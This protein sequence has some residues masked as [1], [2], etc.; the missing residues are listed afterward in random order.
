[1]KNK[2]KKIQITLISIGFILI[3][4]TY[5]YYPY[6]NKSKLSKI[7]KSAENVEKQISE[8]KKTIFKDVEY[9]GYYDLNK[10]FIIKSEEATMIN[11]EP[12]IV[13]MSKMHVVLYLSD[14]R[15]VNITS[16]QGRY[17]KITYDCYFEKNVIAKDG[18][19][20]ISAENLDLLAEENSVKAY[21]KV[22]INYSTGSLKAD[23]IDYDF[24]T[25]YFRVSMFGNEDVK[26][27]VV[28]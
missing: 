16:D 12:D 14:E 4:A 9:K 26:M 13:Y 2:Q 22:N 24:E 27:K 1:M 17:N 8:D 10:P 6:L 3:F 21:N 15:I 11:N 5:F 23:K 20:Q 28:K 7:E 18:E 19:T 25:K